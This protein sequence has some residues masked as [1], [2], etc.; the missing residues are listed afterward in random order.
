MLL[1]EAKNF[2]QQY[3]DKE[4]FRDLNLSIT[5]KDKIGL[6]GP[7]GCGKSTFLKMLAGVLDIGDGTRLS[8]NQLI[9]EYLPQEL[10]GDDEHTI[11]ETI[12]LAQSPILKTV[13]DYEEALQAVN[14]PDAGE[15]DQERFLKASNKMDEEDAWQVETTAK[16][17][18]NRLGLENIH[19]KMGSLSGGEKKKVSLAATLIRPANLI[20]LDEPTNHLDYKTIA[21]LEEELAARHCALVVVTH[22]RYFLDR[23]CNQ[24]VELD[25]GVLTPYQ[26]NYS[27]Y[28][29]AK[30]NSELEKAER[31]RKLQRL[32]KKE[33]LWMRKGVEARRTKQKARIERFHDLEGQLGTQESANLT[34][35][36]KH[37]RLGKK[38]I[39]IENLEKIREGQPIIKDFSYAFTK[40]DAI[41]IVG[42]NGSGKSTFFNLLAGLDKDYSGVIDVG[43]T[44]RIGYYRQHNL[45]MDPNLKIIDYVKEHGEYIERAD[46]SRVSASR[47]LESFLFPPSVQ[48]K[49]IEVLSGG[50]KRRLYLLAILMSKINMLILDEP[51]NDLDISTIQILEEY[52]DHFPGPILVASHDRY[53]L[54]RVVSD[55][56]AFEGNGQ[57]LRQ[58]G[59][60]SDFIT[61]QKALEEDEKETR[62]EKVEKTTPKA[63]EPPL[64][65]TWKESKEYET[66]EEEIMMAEAL[67]ERIEAEMQKHARDFG[68]LSELQ[69]EKEEADQNLEQ[70][71]ER[72]AYLEDKQ[73]KILAQ[74]NK[75]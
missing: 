35:S 42:A 75:S 54:D 62:V 51:T 18:L 14:Q 59:N 58:N 52:L 4:I 21:W 73:Q 30:A 65:L 26:G 66:I 44:V 20:L 49:R 37:A 34:M 64:K 6:I 39:E 24:I 71:L 16:Q 38:I 74:K 63:K 68:K 2:S 31:Q 50:E 27:Q 25:Q 17:I 61:R 7:N 13:R 9:M 8:S 46:G 29:E 70:L 22:D 40:D 43:E 28:I 11:L 41:G 55:I 56:F 67:V 19:A 57:L 12:F 5:D 45:E 69:K 72:W 23:V 47:M 48:Y 60:F 3:G 15:A 1:L 53:F 10:P 36:F 33:L 32:Y